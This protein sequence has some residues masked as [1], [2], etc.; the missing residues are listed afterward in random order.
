MNEAVNRNRQ[1]HTCEVR[2][3]VQQQKA[4]ARL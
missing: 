4:C 1:V 2:V 3:L